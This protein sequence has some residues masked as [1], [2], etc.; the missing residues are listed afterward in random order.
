MSMFSCNVGLPRICMQLGI[1]L[2]VDKDTA[3]NVW[4]LFSASNCFL[5]VKYFMGIYDF[6]T[7]YLYFG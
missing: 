2:D 6:Y 4:D 3:Q 7:E 1:N 5:T